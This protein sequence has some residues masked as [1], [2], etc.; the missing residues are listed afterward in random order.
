MSNIT[1]YDFYVEADQGT[2]NPIVGTETSPY[3]EWVFYEDHEKAIK[4]ERNKA[5]LGIADMLSRAGYID[6]GSIVASMCHTP[7]THSLTPP[8]QH[9]TP[10][11]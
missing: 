11:P 10:T 4:D 2:W 3:G 7:V 5:I 8:P 1:R 9:D 6:V